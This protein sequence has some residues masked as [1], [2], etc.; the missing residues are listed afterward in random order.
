MKLKVMSF[1]VRL[2][3]K[4]DGI[5]HFPNRTSRIKEMLDR[6]QPDIIGFQ[7]MCDKNRAWFRNHI[8]DE[9]I[10]IGC[11]RDANY[12]NEAN[13][14]AFKKN[15][16][17]L[18]S[19]ETKQLSLEPDVPGSRYE[20]V[21]QSLNPRIYCHAVLS[22]DGVSKPIHVYNTHLDYQ[23]Q[24][25]K[26]LGM[27][28]ILGS[29]S[30]CR[31]QFVLTG[32]MNATPDERAMKMPLELSSKAVIDATASIGSTFHGWGKD[33][34]TGKIDYIFTDAALVS[35]RA[36]DDGPVDGIWISDH[37]PVVAELEFE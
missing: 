29:I 16:F 8:T 11:G 5:N 26:I 17:E 28:Q 20:G 6:E 14:I 15:S 13:S 3:H 7:E 34:T 19:F 37:F 12:R 25:A 27:A 24:L 33:N 1:N 10:I 21:D 32:D 18:I 22:H 30:S 4:G 36:I 23:S 31:G 35:A 9:Y 2:D